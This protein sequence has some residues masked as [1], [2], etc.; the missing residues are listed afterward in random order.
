M[1]DSIKKTSED[2]LLYDSV[3]KGCIE[4]GLCQKDCR[5][6]QKYG[7]PKQIA[8]KRPEM[9][10]ELRTSFECS[11]CWQCT[12][13][14]PKD[15]DPAAMFMAMRREASRAG[16]GFFQEH[17]RILQ[18]EKWGTSPVI[19]WY[20]LPEGCETVLFPGCAM[21]GSRSERV[22]DL[23]KHLQ[24]NI[25]NLG[26][27]LDCC[28]KP[29]HDLGRMDYFSRTFG[30][31]RDTLVG[32]G[33]KEVLV[34]CPSCHRVWQDYGYPVRVRSMYEVLAETEPAAELSSPVEVT[35]HDPCPTRSDSRIQQSVRTMLEK[36]GFALHE[37]KHHGQKT[38]CCGEGGAACYIAPEFAGN[39]TKTRAREAGERYMVTYCAGC[40]HF[41]GRLS[42]VGH[43]A[44]MFFEPD[45]T[46][47]GQ[48]PVA[49]SPWTWLKR[50][51]LKQKLK[52]YVAAGIQGVRDRKGKVQYTP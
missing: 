24:K 22:L 26:I 44:D 37:M 49:R 18:Y 9:P 50:I 51:L 40:T 42:A 31:L 5:F 32:N 47:A 25:P 2:L 7:M 29:S 11:L 14:C 27:V 34:A 46:L 19:S 48:V 28:T 52:K 16:H 17:R 3:A 13:V 35:V 15:I 1:N 10:A 21:A 23:Y 30:A 4:C 36:T 6:L 43:I 8:G 20:G 38:I 33:V 41:L 39:W 12:A 45:K